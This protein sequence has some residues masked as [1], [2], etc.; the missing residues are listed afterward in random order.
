[1]PSSDSSALIVARFLR[2]N[3]YQEVGLGLV[4]RP[5]LLV[6]LNSSRTKPLLARQ[7]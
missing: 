7:A 6:N 3:Q 2:S 4:S 1:M 5:V